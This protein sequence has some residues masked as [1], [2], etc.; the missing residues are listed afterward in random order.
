MLERKSNK[1]PYFFCED[2]PTLADLA[3]F[4]FIESP[5]P[6]LKALGF[7]VQK[8]AKLVGVAQAVGKDAQVAAYRKQKNMGKPEL[9]YFNGPGRGELTRLAFTAGGVAFTD[10]RHEMG[11]WPSIKN[12][13]ESVPAK[14]FGSMPCIKHGDVHLA[15]S[16]ATAIYAASLGI[17]KERLGETMDKRSENRA[18]E[19][20]VLG[21]HADAQAAMYKCLFGDDESK[22]KGQ[23]A[24]PNA[25]GPVLKGLERML[26]RKTCSGPFFFSERGPTLADLAVYNLIESPFPGFKALKVDLKEYPK[27]NAVGEAVAKDPK[28]QAYAAA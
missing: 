11:A 12:D 1:S 7:D 16:Q 21:A 6:G 3:V 28:I 4:D 26:E 24:L 15:Q 5:F 13:R 2:G 20:M 25:I 17:W 22:K 9:I 19:L 23:E 8:Y 18:T 10:T 27:V 14:C